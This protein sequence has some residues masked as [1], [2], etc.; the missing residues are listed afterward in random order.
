MHLHKVISRRT[1]FKQ[2]VFCW[3]LEGQCQGSVD[4]DPESDPHQNIMDPQHCFSD[5]THI[6]AAGYSGPP[7]LAGTNERA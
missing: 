3:R 5:R 4:P 7:S 2:Y 6:L 1:V